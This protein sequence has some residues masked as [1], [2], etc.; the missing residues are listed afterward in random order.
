MTCS[1]AQLTWAFASIVV[2]WRV[3]PG[4]VVVTQLVTHL[5]AASV[6]VEPVN[7]ARGAVGAQPMVR[8]AHG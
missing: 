4:T 2:R 8:E 7:Q 1:S 6:G 5:S 3:A